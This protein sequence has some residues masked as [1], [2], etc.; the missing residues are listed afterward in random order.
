V[1]FR[2]PRYSICGWRVPVQQ[3]TRLE[4]VI[5]LKTAKALGLTI[6]YVARQRNYRVA[7]MLVALRGCHAMSG[8]S[9]ESDPA[10]TFA[11]ACKITS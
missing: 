5:N 9:P 7:A 1:A 2:C 10:R 3:A 8:L 11:G 6:N 4:V